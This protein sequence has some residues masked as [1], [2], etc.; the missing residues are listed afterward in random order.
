ML[1]SS[2]VL[3]SKQDLL[4]VFDG[5]RSE[6]DEHNDRRER[7]I[8]V[9]SFHFLI[10]PKLTES[11]TSRDITNLSKKLIFLLHRLST[12]ETD[13]QSLVNQSTKKLHEIQRLFAGQKT[14][15]VGDRFWRYQRAVSPGL[16]EYIEALSFAYYLEHDMLITWQQTQDTLSDKFGLVSPLLLFIGPRLRQVCSSSRYLWKNTYWEFRISQES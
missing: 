5:F 14:D 15:L 1:S 3:A 7:L 8:K 10:L 9:P 4:E 16:Q 11:K 2:K 12:D 6:L 13:L